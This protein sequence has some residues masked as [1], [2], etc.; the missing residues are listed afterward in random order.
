MDLRNHT[1]MDA[2]LFATRIEEMIRDPKVVAGLDQGEFDWF[3]LHDPML[4]FIEQLVAAAGEQHP[5]D[6]GKL[7]IDPGKSGAN[8]IGLTPNRDTV[9]VVDFPLLSDDCEYRVLA[10]YNLADELVRYAEVGEQGWDIARNIDQLEKT[11]SRL[12]DAAIAR[13]WELPG[14]TDAYG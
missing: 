8:E 5:D 2:E 11:I 14:A 10:R 7:R 6:P 9:V 3:D 13:K 4:S 12:R 1:A